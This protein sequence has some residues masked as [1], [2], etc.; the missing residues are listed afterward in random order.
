MN[1]AD[2]THALGD[3]EHALAALS[4]KIFGNKCEKY[5]NVPMTLL[6][7]QNTHIK[8]QKYPKMLS[9][10]YVSFKVKKVI[11]VYIKIQKSQNTLIQLH[12]NFFFT[13]G[14]NM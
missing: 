3:A 1:G 11:A 12:N 4:I 9:L 5:L 13:L 14:A 10:C 2:T 7:I 8:I 6:I